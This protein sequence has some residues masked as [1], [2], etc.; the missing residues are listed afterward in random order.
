MGER[1][2]DSILLR[3]DLNGIQSIGNSIRS[4]IFACLLLITHGW[5]ASRDKAVAGKCLVILPR[6]LEV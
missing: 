3:D 5:G 2:G 4:N 1:E 6:L